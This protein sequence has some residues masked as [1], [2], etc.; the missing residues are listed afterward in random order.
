[1]VAAYYP[2]R[3]VTLKKLAARFPGYE[4]IDDL[5]SDRLDHIAILKQRGKG[6]VNS[7]VSSPPRWCKGLGGFLKLFG[8]RTALLTLQCFLARRR[9]SGPRR[10]ARKRARRN[11]SRQNHHRLHDP[12]FHLQIASLAPVVR[13]TR[14]NRGYRTG[15]EHDNRNMLALGF[16]LTTVSPLN[17]ADCSFLLPTLTSPCASTLNSMPRWPV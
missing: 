2:P 3:A 12:A 9:K 5:E 14:R 8:D 17:Y 10:R 13:F 15:R 16:T 6:Y 7:S 1:M 4:G 11:P